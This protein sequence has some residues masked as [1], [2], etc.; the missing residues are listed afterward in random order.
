MQIANKRTYSLAAERQRDLIRQAIT[1]KDFNYY[2]RTDS[3]WNEKN[4]QSPR[5]QVYSHQ[6]VDPRTTFKPRVVHLD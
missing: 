6:N 5:L 3:L 1:I 4:R 2:N